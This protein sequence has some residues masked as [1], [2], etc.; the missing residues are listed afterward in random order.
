MNAAISATVM[1]YVIFVIVI[2]IIFIIIIAADLPV[3]LV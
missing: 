2:I 1:N 3:A